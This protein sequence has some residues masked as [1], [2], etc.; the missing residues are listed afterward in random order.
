M[1]REWLELIR[2][3]KQKTHKHVAD[4][5]GIKRQY[6]GMIENGVSNPSVEVAKKIAN[7]LGFKW[8]LFFEQKSN[9]TLLLETNSA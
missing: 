4:A 8:T 1:K 2:K 7:F 9:E 5:C 3:K 6:Y